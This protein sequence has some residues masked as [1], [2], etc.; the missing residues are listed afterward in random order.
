MVRR[1]KWLLLRG[2][3]RDQRHWGS[4]PT[5]FEAEVSGSKVFSVD[6]P[7]TGT[8]NGRRSPT[9]I[10]G[11]MEDVRRRALAL[12]GDAP[13]SWG[14]LAVSLGG[15][16]AMDWTGTH[17]EDFERVVLINTS[18]AN[19]SVPWKRMD[20]RVLPHVAQALVERD[21]VA[22][23]K[24]ILSITARL[25][26]E[27]DPLARAW[28]RYQAERPMAR[29]DVLRQLMAAT[30][31]RAPAKIS[32]PTLVLSGARDPFTSPD[33]PRR[34]ALHFGA[35]HR[36]HPHAGHDLPTDA[37]SWIAEQVREWV[38]VVTAL[39]SRGA[40]PGGEHGKRHEDGS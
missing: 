35:P 4:F 19:L 14:L 23:E 18:A 24:R 33:C 7:G 34:L 26:K 31:F 39:G 36:I 10:R 2:L 15:M 1:M 5:L 8:E 13:G 38:A 21:P 11:I 9:S 30:R 22:R 25:L 37:G 12:R 40:G 32:I 3:A 27:P 16:V 6:L 28:A 20:L 17:P 29:L